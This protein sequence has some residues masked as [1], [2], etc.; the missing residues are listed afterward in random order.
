MSLAVCDTPPVPA[1][2]DHLER[3]DHR[4]ATAWA[5]ILE[6]EFPGIGD[7]PHRVQGLVALKPYR[8]PDKRPGVAV[9]VEGGAYVMVAGCPDIFPI[10]GGQDC[11]LNGHDI[12]VLTTSP[13][14]SRRYYATAVAGWT[15][16][17]TFNAALRGTA[18][19]KDGIWWPAEKVATNTSTLL[20]NGW[21]H[22]AIW[23][24]AVLV[25]WGSAISVPNGSP[26]SQWIERL[27]VLASVGLFVA[28]ATEAVARLRRG[29]S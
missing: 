22:A 29:H 13:D 20:R 26:I 10:V 17:N 11:V 6:R 25:I 5:E 2:R 12:R 24:V 23:A 9:L 7:Q 14:E 28:L 19:L 21:F 3:L 4:R 15:T 1:L 18:P 8:N 16:P 27:L